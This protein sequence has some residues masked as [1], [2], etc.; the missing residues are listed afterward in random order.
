MRQR[1][2]DGLSEE[3]RNRLSARDKQFALKYAV[4][5]GLKDVSVIGPE[6]G[7]AGNPGTGEIKRA[8]TGDLTAAEEAYM[9]RRAASAG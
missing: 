8:T 4:L 2:L 1:W 6:E 5:V 9:N 7:D 3:G